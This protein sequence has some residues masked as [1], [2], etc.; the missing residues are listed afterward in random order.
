LA[1]AS[2]ATAAH[3]KITQA[4]TAQAPSVFHNGTLCAPPFIPGIPGIPG[5]FGTGFPFEIA[6][7]RDSIGALAEPALL[8]SLQENV[9]T[10]GLYR[11]SERAESS[12]I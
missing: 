7:T 11:L 9:G 5:V 12:G 8:G 2:P 1:N 6:K 4:N 3:I 10:A